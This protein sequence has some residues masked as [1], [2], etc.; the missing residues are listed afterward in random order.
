M[1][2]QI[3]PWD[4]LACCWAVKQEENNNNV[5]G[6]K[7]RNANVKSRFV[8]KKI[9]FCLQNPSIS[10]FCRGIVWLVLH[11]L[12]GA[13]IAQGAQL[14]EWCGWCCTSSAVHALHRVLRGVVWLVLHILS[15]ACIAQGALLGELCGWCCTSSV[16]HAL[17]RV[18]CSGSGVVGATRP[19]RCMHCTGCSVRGSI[20]SL[21]LWAQV[22][23][24]YEHWA[25][26][27]YCCQTGLWV[28]A[29]QWNSYV[30]LFVRFAVRNSFIAKSNTID[31]S[32]VSDQNGVFWLCHCRDIPFW[33]ETLDL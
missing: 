8:L 19:Q 28:M 26:Q 3:C 17:H 2:E 23:T 10:G 6:K 27:D 29:K 1:S 31:I 12:S 33:S 7:N 9:F 30:L 32:R 25:D 13:C 18:L 4:T 21:V 14:G 24:W 22:V 11:V 5:G 16:V 20:V 15:G